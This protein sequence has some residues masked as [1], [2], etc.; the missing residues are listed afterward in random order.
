MSRILPARFTTSHTTKWSA[1]SKLIRANLSGAD[2]RSC[3]QELTPITLIDKSMV[4]ALSAFCP[5]LQLHNAANTKTTVANVIIAIIL[6]DFLIFA[7]FGLVLNCAYFKTH[8]YT[9]STRRNEPDILNAQLKD[10]V[11]ILVEYFTGS[12]RDV[13]LQLGIFGIPEGFI[14]NNLRMPSLKHN[15]DRLWGSP[16]FQETT[17]ED[18]IEL[19]I[20]P[21]EL[22]LFN[23]GF[24]CDLEVDE[25]NFFNDP[26]WNKIPSRCTSPCDSPL[27]GIFYDTHQQSSASARSTPIFKPD[28][29]GFVH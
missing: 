23:M 28:A 18:R 14:T 5:D 19:D 25:E 20:T 15:K 22:A 24:A 6:D 8:G 12:D 29:K 4:M 10:A 16:C 2:A 7:P 13:K 21:P 1:W 11:R 26:D 17:V 9:T 27:S 3:I